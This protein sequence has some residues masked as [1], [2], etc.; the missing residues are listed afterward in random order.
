MTMLQARLLWPLTP[1]AII[2]AACFVCRS[3]LAETP[4]MTYVAEYEA[5]YKDRD[6]GTTVFSVRFDGDSGTYI[7]ESSTQVKG[8]LKIASPNPIV[9]RSRFRYEDR[10]V[11][12]QEFHN[13]DG[14]RS[15]DENQ[16]IVFDWSLAKAQISGEHG[17]VEVDLAA[18]V[19]DR[20]SLQVAL[21]TDLANGRM[22]GPYI[23]AD[24]DSFDTYHYTRQ[25]DKTVETALGKLEVVSYVQQR[26]GSSRQT[27]FEL[28][29]GL[30]FV[31][32]RIEQLRDGE[33]RSA[34]VIQSLN[35]D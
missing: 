26:E 7:Y 4:P 19:I 5:F 31:P 22:P 24:A 17:T 9:D 2:L 27:V 20:G 15:G 23:V 8:L 32:V 33:V 35:A 3:A 16:H 34:F 25:A 13:K 14:S 6:I 11:R 28:A 30:G 10:A 1:A 12:P 18:G 21:T 29:P